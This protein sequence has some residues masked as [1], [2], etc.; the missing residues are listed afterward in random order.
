MTREGER[1]KLA[2]Y[3]IKTTFWRLPNTRVF[4]NQG[5]IW[6]VRVNHFILLHANFHAT[7]YTLSPKYHDFDQ[8][9]G[10]SVP[11]PSPILAK[12]GMQH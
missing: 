7:W 1:E 11:S 6:H 9:F 3:T 5:Q 12:L 2:K 4:A 10:A 8:L